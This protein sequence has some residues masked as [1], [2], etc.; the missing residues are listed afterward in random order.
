MRGRLAAHS[1]VA[2]RLDQP[3]SKMMLPDAV[4]ENPRCERVFRVRQPPGQLQPAAPGFAGNDL[5]TENLEEPPGNLIPQT[6][7]IPPLLH[8]GVMRLSLGDGV[9]DVEFWRGGRQ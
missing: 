9:G 1:E 8:A 7:R 6:L 3:L 4:D 2:G 5:T